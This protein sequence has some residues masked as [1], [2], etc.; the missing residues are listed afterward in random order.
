MAIFSRLASVSYNTL[1]GRTG[2]KLH[3]D[4]IT[5]AAH[6]C[7]PKIY[8]PVDK[9]ES[10]GALPSQL[11]PKKLSGKQS[12]YATANDS[13]TR[14]GSRHRRMAPL[15]EEEETSSRNNWMLWQFRKKARRLPP[16]TRRRGCRHRAS[17]LLR[18]GLEPPC[19]CVVQ[20]DAQQPGGVPWRRVLAGAGRRRPLSDRESVPQCRLE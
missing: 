8:Q 2:Q 10:C 11:A 6:L 13:I 16:G 18:E 1:A 14:R 12:K 4:A 17:R 19:D 9:L 20:G 15:Q 5:A 3:S 7:S